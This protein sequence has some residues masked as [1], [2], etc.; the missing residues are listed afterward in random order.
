VC[1]R[2]SGAY[3]LWCC[4][5]FYCWELLHLLNIIIIIIIIVVVIVITIIIIVV[6]IVIIRP[7]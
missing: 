3:Q 6:V 5:G 1:I 4:R 7:V 2:T